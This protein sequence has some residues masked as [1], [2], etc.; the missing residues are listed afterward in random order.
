MV[1]GMYEYV[2]YFKK[3]SLAR[4]RLKIHFLKENSLAEEN[5]CLKAAV[6]FRDSRGKSK[7]RKRSHENRLPREIP[8]SSGQVDFTCA[9]ACFLFSRAGLDLLI[10]FFFKLPLFPINKTTCSLKCF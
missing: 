5:D 6:V 9:Q 7:S 10:F 1:H 8:K 2:V 3:M 4:C